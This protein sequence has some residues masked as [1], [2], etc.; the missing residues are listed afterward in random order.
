MNYTDMGSKLRFCI[1]VP[2]TLACL[3]LLLL[4]YCARHLAMACFVAMP[5]DFY[6]DSW[7]A[8]TMKKWISFKKLDVTRL[9]ILVF[10]EAD[11]LLAEDGFKDDSLRIMKEIE[12]FNSSCQLSLDAVKQYK[13]HYP[14]ELQIEVIKDYIFELGENVGQTI[15][16][17]RTRQSA[18]ILHKSLID[19]GYE[20][21]SIQGALDHEERDKIVICD[22]VPPLHSLLTNSIF[23]ALDM[24]LQFSHLKFSKDGKPIY[25]FL[26][27]STFSEYT[28]SHAKCVIKIN[29]AAPLDKVCVLS[30][31]ICTGLGATLNVA[32]QKP[33]S[34]VVVFGLGAVGLVAAEGAR[35]AGASRIIRVDILSSRQEQGRF[36]YCSQFLT[37]SV[38]VEMTDGGVDRALECTG[39]VEAAIATFESVHDI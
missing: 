16:F 2:D 36:H 33:G 14:D 22:R 15:I 25:H 9:T 19:I 39:H 1:S 11:Q 3:V 6:W 35:L 8:G 18:K 37:F 38:I 23:A 24:K 4:H 10:D 29:L 32:K 28:I 31:G 7:Q 17:V 26:G 5:N 12:K 13:V 34:T 27:T 30:C 20:V 21:T